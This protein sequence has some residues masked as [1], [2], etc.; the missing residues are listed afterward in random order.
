MLCMLGKKD[1]HKGEE[2][3][4][5]NEKGKNH[6][7][8]TGMISCAFVWY[9]LWGVSISPALLSAPPQYLICR[10]VSSLLK[11]E[12]ILNEP[13]NAQPFQEILMDPSLSLTRLNAWGD[14]QKC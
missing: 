9:K 5:Q 11:M 14:S 8:C 4:E 2:E 13:R 3:A 12:V 6:G 7:G 10:A 1:L